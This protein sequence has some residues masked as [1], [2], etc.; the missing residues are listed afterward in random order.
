VNQCLIP[1][2]RLSFLSHSAK[3]V[4]CLALCSALH[5]NAHTYRL[6]VF[7]DH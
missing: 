7:K 6:L 2:E 5:S 4:A 1:C 3:T